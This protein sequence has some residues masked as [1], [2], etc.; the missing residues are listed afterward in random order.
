V[1]DEVCSKQPDG[2]L[3][4]LLMASRMLSKVEVNNFRLKVGSPI[5][6]AGR[7]IVFSSSESK[8]SD[9]FPPTATPRMFE[10]DLVS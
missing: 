3:I 9:Y 8:A 7:V 10:K 6:V 5:M 2:F 1:V 4:K